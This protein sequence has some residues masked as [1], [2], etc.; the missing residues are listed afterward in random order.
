ML[1]NVE[2]KYK[3]IHYNLYLLTQFLFTYRKVFFTAPAKGLAA[4]CSPGQK[5]RNAL[6]QGIS[7][8]RGLPKGVTFKLITKIQ[9]F[10]IK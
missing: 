9:Q 5:S 2:N 6:G 10:S 1:A 4:S 3:D 8:R 7:I